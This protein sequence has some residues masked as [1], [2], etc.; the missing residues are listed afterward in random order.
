MLAQRPAGL[1]RANPARAEDFAGP[2]HVLL[3]T[4]CRRWW[5]ERR[6]RL[7][8]RTVLVLM[9]LVAT[10]PLAVLMCVQLLGNMR[11]E[12][13]Q[14]NDELA[15]EA[16]VLAQSVDRELVASIEALRILG[17]SESLRVGDVREFERSVA[18]RGP[19]RAGWQGVFLTDTRGLVIFDTTGGARRGAYA[20]VAGLRDM[21]RE[22]K[23]LVTGLLRHPRGDGPVTAIGVPVIIDGEL[24][25]GLGV[26][27]PWAAWQQ[28]LER[29]T[30]SDVRFSALFDR[31][32]VAIAHSVEPARFVG[33]PLADPPAQGDTD[34]TAGQQVPASGWGV[35]LAVPAQ[36][37]A[38]SQLRSAAAAW[39]V[40][41]G[42][43]LL[44]VTLALLVARRVTGPLSQLARDGE[45]TLEGP[46]HVREIVALHEALRAARERDQA[47]RDGL[48]R[49][50]DEFETLFH[51]SPIGLA[52]AQDRECHAVWRNATMQKL[53]ASP[54]G[55]GSVWQDGAPLPPERMPLC[56]AARTGQAVAMT[57]LEFRRPGRPTLHAIANAVPLR[58]EHGR[59]RGAIGAMVDITPRKTAEHEL[60]R[61]LA[62][63]G[64]SQRLLDLAQEAG[65]VGF[66]TYD[67]VSDALAWTPG[68]VKLFGADVP[69]F[70][71]T[72]AEWIDLIEAEDRVALDAT[73]RQAMAQRQESV[74][75]EYRVRL[76]GGALR[77]LASRLSIAYGEQGEPLRMVGVTLDIDE[78]RRMEQAGA[79]LVVR[80]Q[81]ARLLA[82]E[83]SRAKDEFLAMLGHELRNPLSAVSSAVEVLR[84]S[85]PGSEMARS[86]LDVTERQVLHLAHMVGDLL[87][88]TRVVAGKVA[89]AMEAVDLGEVARR[90]VETLRMTGASQGHVFA[91]RT[92]PAWVQGDLTRLEQV[93]NNLVGNA[94]KYTPPGRSIQVVVQAEADEAVLQ[95]ADEG[96]GIAEEL[97]PRVFD[98]FVQG[99]Q[100]LDRAAGGLGVG[101]TLVKRLVEMH[102]GRVVA[103][104]SRSGACFEVRLPRVV[105]PPVQAEAPMPGERPGLRVLVVE[106]NA[107]ALSTLSDM[108]R[109]DGHSV[110]GE[111]DGREGLAALLA[112]WPDAAIVDIGLPGI[113][114]LQLA[115]SARAKGYPGRL[116]ALSGYGEREDTQRTRKAGFDAH[117]VKPVDLRLL[118]ATLEE[119]QRLPAHA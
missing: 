28:L 25:F 32:R 68:Q 60:L 57:E 112:Q 81:A 24:R 45:A 13:R 41:A 8:L 20:P 84:R 46:L 66:F 55:E 96:E 103:S 1:H 51:S 18:G 52:L 111:R 59:P 19:L 118:R 100:P 106:D 71:S 15:R 16:T 27:V 58:D 50:A 113:D 82:E 83:A 26:W 73:L 69:D 88:V 117:L 109:L 10:V 116:V 80:E 110:H 39:S 53:F 5:R 105:A 94:I 99:E 2:R 97:L 70:R 9:L 4:A 77:W 11:A 90:V 91:V 63:L 33:L 98:V 85:P 3:Q 12:Q 87:D 95:V 34:Y 104:S 101:L 37:I 54:E 6:L 30:P 76:P 48:Q 29:A 114:G 40:A 64:Q 17:L 61:V 36:P 72:L 67:A 86:A 31:Q 14:I 119:A 23:P 43:L 108:L 21:L 92:E 107:D 75:V 44:G 78:R 74:S 38:M 89:L 49:K 7:S 115:L 42:C 65:H 62:E 35:R 56:V 22:R 102:G 93:I 79:A 47:A